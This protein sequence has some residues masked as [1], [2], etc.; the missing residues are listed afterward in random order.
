MS[1]SERISK[2]L[3]MVER[4]AAAKPVH[5]YAV[6]LKSGSYRAGVKQSSL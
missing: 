4:L 3:E 5:M 1:K 2:L 6:H